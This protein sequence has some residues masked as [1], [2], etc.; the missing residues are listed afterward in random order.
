MGVGLNFFS[1][2]NGIASNRLRA[3]WLCRLLAEIPGEKSPRGVA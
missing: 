2:L 3:S 1:D